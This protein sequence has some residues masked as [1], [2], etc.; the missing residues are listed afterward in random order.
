MKFNVSTSFKDVNTEGQ[1]K[2]VLEL[3]FECADVEA[4]DGLLQI[5][6]DFFQSKEEEKEQKEAA[7]GFQID[8][9]E[10]EELEEWNGD[11]EG[12]GLPKRPN[13]RNP[14]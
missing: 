7:L 6:M 8:P 3:Y 1:G 11:E 10:E 2:A 13:N 14:R 4:R 9:P 5:I 12:K